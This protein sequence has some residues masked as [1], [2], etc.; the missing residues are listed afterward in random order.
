MAVS[1]LRNAGYDPSALVTMLKVLERVQP[2]KSGGFN[3]TH[4]S[5]AARLANLEKISLTGEGRTTRAYRI[6]RFTSLQSD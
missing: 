3:T 2:L 6:S 4:P 5:P 1:L